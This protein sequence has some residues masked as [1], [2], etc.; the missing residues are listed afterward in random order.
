VCEV[1][2]D[3]DFHL[4]AAGFLR[5]AFSLISPW[6]SSCESYLTK[7]LHSK[8]YNLEA[9]LKADKFTMWLVIASVIIFSIC[10]AKAG[11]KAVL[12]NGGFNKENNHN[13]H[14]TQLKNMYTA[15]LKQGCKTSD[16]HVFSSAGTT[17]G[18]DYRKDPIDPNSVFS[19]K[20]YKFDGVNKVSNLYSA[21]RNTLKTKIGEIA[22]TFT[23]EDKVF[24]YL[25]DHGGDWNG[26]KGL[27]PWDPNGD[28]VLFSSKDLEDALSKAPK[29]T[30][31]SVWA[32]CCY[33][34]TFNK[35]ERPNTCVATATDEYHLGNYFWSNWDEYVA[36]GTYAGK[37]DLTVDTKFAE[38][39]R[40]NGKVSLQQAS[41]LSSLDTDDTS[42]IEAGTIEKGCMVGPRNSVEQF[43]FNKLDFGNKQLCVDDISKMLNETAP[44]ELSCGI[45]SVT[46]PMEDLI[47]IF[48][49]LRGDKS[50]L[51]KGD[52]KKLAELVKE[53]KANLVLV[54]QAT[55]IQQLESLD[56]EFE[57]LSPAEKVEKAY[58]LQIMAK[59]VKSN[60]VKKSNLFNLILKNQNLVLKSLF[61]IKA[62]PADKQELLKRE[63]CL[64]T[65]MF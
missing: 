30:K 50:K 35:I 64:N 12:V 43:M 21:D 39:I 3:V 53:L 45:N 26:K 19:S 58:S 32:D 51:N 18:E 20:D 14:E 25:N 49:T 38:A 2:C 28:N 1:P 31:M 7:K 44:E 56:K 54:K 13:I 23:P 42:F 16:I 62:S 34:G 46:Q 59:N 11:C 61:E 29:E 36:D 47:K 22:G 63:Q 4:E 37:V 41:S 9:C 52:R 10:E 33:C 40:G 48:T 8:K 15:L 5:V 55:E 65:P 6:Q 17:D 24:V 57:G 60:L 27:V